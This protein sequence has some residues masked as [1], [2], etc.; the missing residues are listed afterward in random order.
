MKEK[1][2]IVGTGLG[3]LASGLRLASNGYDVVF[4]EKADTPGG[5]LNNFGKEGFRFDTGPSF[6]V[7]HMNLK[8]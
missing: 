2:L 5:R 1:I 3:G 4:V 7:C 8:N 6:L